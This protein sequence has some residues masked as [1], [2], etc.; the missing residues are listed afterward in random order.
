MTDNDFFFYFICELLKA[1]FPKSNPMAVNGLMRRNTLSVDWE[2]RLFDCDFNQMLAMQLDGNVQTIQEFS[3]DL[4][5][6]RI[7][8]TAPHC[9]GCT[10]GAGSSCGGAVVYAD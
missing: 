6:N 8:Q 7:I 9:F 2:G 3:K 4:L 5:E 10:A 1:G